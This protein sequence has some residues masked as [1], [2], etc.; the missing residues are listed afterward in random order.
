MTLSLRVTP[1]FL[2]C[3]LAVSGCSQEAPA[4]QATEAPSP[5]APVTA[6]APAPSANAI[7]AAIATED[8][9][10][11]LELVGAPVYVAGSDALRVTVRIH[12]DGRATLVSEGTAPVRLGA[13]LLGPDGADVAPGVRDF[14]RI[15]IPVIAPGSSTE[16]TSDMPVP[17]LLGL[18]VRLEL[19]QEGVN[20]FS[21]YDQA[22]L[23]LGTF[24]RCAGE[25]ATLC[26]DGQP[27]AGE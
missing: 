18:S 14:H 21:A 17:P 11:R 23:D 1:L 26:S 8:L 25:A 6:P 27:V 5:E 15:D 10:T 19:V 2:A 13:M 9:D 4:P 24:E 16:V 20:W 7:N 12:N 3:A 22:P